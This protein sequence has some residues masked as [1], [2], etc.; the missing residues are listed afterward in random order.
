MS[1]ARELPDYC[2]KMILEIA[3]R[4]FLTGVHFCPELSQGSG[5]G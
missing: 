4:E 5:E 2:L 1:D 3:F